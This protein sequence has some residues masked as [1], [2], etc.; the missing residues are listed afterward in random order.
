MVVAI[1]QVLTTKFPIYSG[2][3]AISSEI[4]GY[5]E[6]AGIDLDVELGGARMSSDITAQVGSLIK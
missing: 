5:T 2:S 4:T 6:I 1:K 3:Y